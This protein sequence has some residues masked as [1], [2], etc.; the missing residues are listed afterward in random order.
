MAIGPFKYNWPGE[1]AYGT[2]QIPFDTIYLKGGNAEY[3]TNAKFV[4]KCI[5]YGD[6][7]VSLYDDLAKK[8]YNIKIEADELKEIAEK[9][10]LESNGDFEVSSKNG[11]G[12]I[13]TNGI[14]SLGGTEYEYGASKVGVDDNPVDQVYIYGQ[15]ADERYAGKDNFDDHVETINVRVDN[16][17]TTLNNRIDDEVSQLNDTIAEKEETLS[18]RINENTE[19]ISAHNDRLNSLETSVNDIQSTIEADHSAF[20]LYKGQIE[21]KFNDVAEAEDTLR[22]EVDAKVTETV[23]RIASYDETLSEAINQSNTAV[24]TLTAVVDI[25]RQDISNLQNETE[26]IRETYATKEELRAVST[27]DLEN[28][29]LT[30]NNSDELTQSIIDHSFENAERILF[31]KGSYVL[32]TNDR[33]IIETPIDFSNIK[34]IKGEYPAKVTLNKDGQVAPLNVENVKFENI[35][36]VVGTGTEAFEIDDGERVMSIKANG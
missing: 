29:D 14:L 11:N 31:K 25:A 18:E 6:V 20:E 15:E 24:S 13:S 19:S 16:E 3:I 9:F 23:N 1:S 35:S 5:K 30:I 17:V 2:A 27:E 33:N 28:F 34:Y 10:I 12:K 7:T 26:D 8:Y 4:I 21:S 36:F 32:N 22:A